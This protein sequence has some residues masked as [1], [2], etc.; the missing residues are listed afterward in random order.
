M[1]DAEF[2]RRY[3]P[4][5]IAGFISAILGARVEPFKSN[6]LLAVAAGFGVGLVCGGVDLL[7][8][9]VPARERIF[10]ALAVA[11]AAGA[12]VGL[13]ARLARSK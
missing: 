4:P 13:A 6:L 11:A 8:S 5:F 2:L 3:A 12:A 10:A 1:S 7:M 9:W